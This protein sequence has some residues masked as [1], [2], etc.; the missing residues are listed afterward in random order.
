MEALALFTE[1]RVR[2][3]RTRCRRLCLV[4]HI[5]RHFYL[6]GIGLAEREHIAVEFQNHRV[7][8]GRI[9]HQ[10]HHRAGYHAHVQKMLAQPACSADSSNEHTLANAY[11]TEIRFH[12][13]V[14]LRLFFNQD[15]YMPNIPDRQK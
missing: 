9:F 10:L 3:S 1:S 12:R 5:V 7:A 4:G 13:L 8:H 11:I 15:L 2:P 14:F 6:R